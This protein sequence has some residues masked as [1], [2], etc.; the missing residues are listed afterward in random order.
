[1]ETNEINNKSIKLIINNKLIDEMINTDDLIFENHFL[2][3]F[4]FELGI[5]LYDV[6]SIIFTSKNTCKFTVRNNLA[7]LPLIKLKKY[8]DK[9]RNIFKHKRDNI[10]IH[11]LDKTLVELYSIILED[12][13]IKK[14]DLSGFSYYNNKPQE[15][16]IDVKF[17]NKSFEKNEKIY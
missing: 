7:T 3:D 15:I 5:R 17:K 16:T 14:F 9:K 4:P 11:Q 13:T 10:I 1:M 2:V 6:V 8:K 12:I